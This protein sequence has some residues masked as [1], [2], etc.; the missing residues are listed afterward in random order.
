[1]KKI[2]NK[3]LFISLFSVILIVGSISCKDDTD[4][5]MEIDVRLF[6]DTN[7]V[8]PYAFINVEKNDIKIKGKANAQG[9][10]EY[11]FALEAILDVTARDT[12]ADTTVTPPVYTPREGE[13]TVRL[14]SGETVR[15]I[16]YIKE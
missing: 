14:K 4:C 15:K 10:F 5:K 11:T 3:S 13:G 2:L 8:V 16:I 12:I 9:K 7:V 6:S 1:M